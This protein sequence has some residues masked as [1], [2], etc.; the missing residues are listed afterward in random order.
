MTSLRAR[1]RAIGSVRG[2]LEMMTIR[3]DMFAVYDEISGERIECR[4][5]PELMM[6]A[7]PL[8]GTR[9]LVRG[10]IVRDSRGRRLASVTSLRPLSTAQSPRAKDLL[11][12]FADHPV[13]LDD[14]SRYIRDGW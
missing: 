12:L 1:W 8:F 13:S 14:W 3:S 7:T 10:E 2:T 6:E 4:C 11:G 9:A 5:S